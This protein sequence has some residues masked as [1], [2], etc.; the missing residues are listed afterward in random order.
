M[1]V[2]LLNWLL[3]NADTRILRVAYLKDSVNS[4]KYLLV[5]R[6]LRKRLPGFSRLVSKHAENNITADPDH[7]SDMEREGAEAAAWLV[8]QLSKMSAA[9]LSGNKLQLGESEGAQ[10][11]MRDNCVAL[12]QA[13]E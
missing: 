11:S 2:T 1:T 6:W 7:L 4:H 9:S 8:T 3:R 13:M 12:N 5:R 10:P